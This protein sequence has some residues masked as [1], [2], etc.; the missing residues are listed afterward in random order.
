MEPLSLLETRKQERYPDDLPLRAGGRRKTSTYCH[1]RKKVKSRERSQAGRRRFNARYGSAKRSCHHVA[2]WKA[3]SV[4]PLSTAFKSGGGMV[5]RVRNSFTKGMTERELLDRTAFARTVALGPNGVAAP[6]V[7]VDPAA[8]K[9]CPS[10]L[11]A[12]LVLRRSFR[13][14][15][16]RRPET[17]CLSQCSGHAARPPSRRSAPP[18]AGYRRISPDRCAPPRPLSIVSDRGGSRRR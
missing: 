6:F 14:A 4:N 12:V 9:T 11:H 16:R 15:V 13:L 18:G 10:L 5:Q 3:C 7:A 1:K 2:G 8:R 17:S